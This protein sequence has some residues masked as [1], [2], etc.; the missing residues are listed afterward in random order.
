MLAVALLTSLTLVQRHLF[1]K[2]RLD[3]SAGN[4]F[5]RAVEIKVSVKSVHFLLLIS[6][7]ILAAH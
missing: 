3:L 4:Y 7:H 1:S 5:R 6:Q 2:L